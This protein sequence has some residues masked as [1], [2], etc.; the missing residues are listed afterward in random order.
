MDLQIANWIFETFGSNKVFLKIAYVLTY[1]GDKWTIILI[2]ALLLAFKKTRKL[3]L[4]ATVTVLITFSFNNYVLKNIIQRDRPFVENPEFL[5]V[6]EL[7]GH[8]LP[9]SYS[10][11]SGHSI[12][13]MCLAVSVFMFHKKIGIG[14]ISLSVVCGITRMIL[15]VHYFTDVLAGFLLGALFAIGIHYLMNLII[16]KIKERKDIKYENNSARN[17]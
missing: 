15:C 16:K 8:G 14:A 2:L 10:M 11:P 3:G 1:I 17:G 4:Y 12:T 7:A 5:K 9:D 6:L 13:S